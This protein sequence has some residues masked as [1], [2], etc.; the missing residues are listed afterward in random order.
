[1][2]FDNRLEKIG[3]QKT[4]EGKEIPLVQFKNLEEKRKVKNKV[5]RLFNNQMFRSILTPRDYDKNIR[6]DKLEREHSKRDTLG[7]IER[8]DKFSK[9]SID[10]ISTFPSFL[11]MA[12]TVLLSKEGDKVFDAFCGHNSRA[13]DVLSLGRK[14]YAYDVHKYPIDFTQRATRGFPQEDWELV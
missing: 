1:M 8:V 13:S 10:V 11:T 5:L 3:G 14:Y 6:L 7:T 12:Y 2:D 9:K 4:L